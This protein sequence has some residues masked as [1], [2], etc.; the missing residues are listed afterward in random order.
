MTIN[1]LHILS[2][3]LRTYNLKHARICEIALGWF[4]NRYFEMISRFFG[5]NFP[6][7]AGDDTDF[8]IHIVEAR[9]LYAHLYIKPKKCHHCPRTK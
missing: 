8:Y 9:G 3:K 7:C 1:N 4:F 5:D 2:W 6:F